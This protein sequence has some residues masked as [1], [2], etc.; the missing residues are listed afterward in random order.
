M[1]TL[2]KEEG[3]VMRNVTLEEM[4]GY[5]YFAHSLEMHGIM[6]S[7]KMLKVDNEMLIVMDSYVKEYPGKM[8]ISLLLALGEKAIFWVNLEVDAEFKL[9][10]MKYRFTNAWIGERYKV[11][12]E[13]FNLRAHNIDLAHE[14]SKIIVSN[15][16]MYAHKEIDVIQY[17]CEV[18][19]YANSFVQE[20][21]L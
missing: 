18:V 12:K 14:Q 5:Q 11:L 10:G 7:N 4:R 17:L 8:D 20:K 9:S 21:N 3:G 1:E 6:L 13:C 2:K 16:T 19:A 15:E